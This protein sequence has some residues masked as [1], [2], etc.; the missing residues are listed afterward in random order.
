M[1]IIKGI[2]DYVNGAIEYMS[3]KKRRFDKI[4]RIKRRIKQETSSVVKGYIV[5]GKHYYKEL[6]DVPNKEMQRVCSTIDDNI[7]EIEQLRCKLEEIKNGCDIKFYC[8]S[9]S[10]AELCDDLCCSNDSIACTRGFCDCEPVCN[11]GDQSYHT[12]NSKD[13]NGSC[14]RNSEENAVSNE[15]PDKN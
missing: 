13:V 11:C 14:D 15:D 5:L 12:S 8:D 4:S 7:R 1:G 10:D 9:V 2:S 3:E 6:R